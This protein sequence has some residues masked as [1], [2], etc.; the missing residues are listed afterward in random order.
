MTVLMRFNFNLLRSFFAMFWNVLCWIGS[1][2]NHTY[3][4]PKQVLQFFH[5]QNHNLCNRIISNS[6]I[7]P[8]TSYI[9]FYTIFICVL[10]GKLWEILW[11]RKYSGDKNCGFDVKLVEFCSQKNVINIAFFPRHEKIIDFVGCNLTFS[12]L[13]T[14]FLIIQ[15]KSSRL[16]ITKTINNP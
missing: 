8:V 5:V 14:H 11:D 9:Y 13:S 12:K 6:I 2:T 16:Q 1:A 15:G 3:H 7:L 10:K 4:I